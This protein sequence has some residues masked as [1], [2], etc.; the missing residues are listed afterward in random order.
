MQVYDLFFNSII[1]QEKEYFKGYYSLIEKSI[2][3]QSD[4]LKRK[5]EKDKK[6]VTPEDIDDFNDYYSD[7]VFGLDELQGVLYKSFIISIFSYIEYYLSY[8]CDSIYKNKKVMFSHKDIKGD[9]VTRAVT[10]IEKTLDIQF[11]QNE[12]LKNDF[13][14]IKLIRN[15]IIHNNAYI[16]KDQY[17]TL[18]N[19]VKNNPSYIEMSYGKLKI[20]KGLVKYLIEIND[21]FISEIGELYNNK[22]CK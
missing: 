6:T 9:G 20:K 10:Y 8:L 13:K 16:N 3:N 17:Q 1:E 4:E 11:P 15:S 12:Q 14:I 2:Q 7:L 22:I 18:N 21:Q 19:F 5:Y